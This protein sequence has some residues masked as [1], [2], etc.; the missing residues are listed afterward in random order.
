ME[1]EDQFLTVEE[2]AALL[3]VSPRTIQRLVT[4]KELSAIRIGRQLRFR[5]EWVD[6]WL[7]RNT[8]EGTED[9]SA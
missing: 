5:R 7:R 9:S 2:L 3:K 6:D 8:S 1:P 4:R